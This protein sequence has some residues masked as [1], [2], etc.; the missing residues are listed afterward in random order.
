MLVFAFSDNLSAENWKSSADFSIQLI[1]LLECMTTPS[2]MSIIIL[3]L[4]NN[5]SLHSICLKVDIITSVS[6]QY[7][8]HG[9]WHDLPFY[10]S[11]ILL[12]NI[13]CFQ[14]L[15]LN[16]DIFQIIPMIIFS[17]FSL[18]LFWDDSNTVVKS[19]AQISREF[20]IWASCKLIGVEYSLPSPPELARIDIRIWKL[21]QQEEKIQ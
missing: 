2:T 10:I 1:Q 15:V 5:K 11:H 4:Y 13:I 12:F 19:F 9:T 17:I 3:P 7:N 8:T 18:Q 16:I 6:R 20:L 21:S 14:I